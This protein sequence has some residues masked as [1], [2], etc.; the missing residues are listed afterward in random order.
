MSSKTGKTGGGVGSNKYGPTGHPCSARHIRPAARRARHARYSR[1]GQAIGKHRVQS[2]RT[3]RAPRWGIDHGEQR[4]VIWQHLG[5]RWDCLSED[6]D[7]GL[8]DSRS[9]LRSANEITVAWRPD[10]DLIAD[11]YEEGRRAAMADTGL[12]ERW[13]E[14]LAHD[15]AYEYC[16]TSDC[17][18]SNAQ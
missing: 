7:G 4:C 9:V 6:G 15:D 8:Y 10:R 18:G 17:D 1:S 16:A 2:A 11:A 5:G 12:T 3:R 13:S 14:T